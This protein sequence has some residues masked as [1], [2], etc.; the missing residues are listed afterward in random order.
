M[1]AF[2]PAISRS[3]LA[4]NLGVLEPDVGDDGDFAVHHIGR[5][6]PAAEADLDDR[7]FD[8]R[9][10]KDQEGG[11]GEESNQVA[12]AAAVPAPCASS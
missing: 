7:P 6:E 1:P 10:A 2:S 5:V 9:V 4:Q 12:S 3:R 8:P 11:G